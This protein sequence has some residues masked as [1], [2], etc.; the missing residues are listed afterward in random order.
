MKSLRIIASAVILFSVA[1]CRLD[2][3]YV[4]GVSQCSEDLWRDEINKELRM[5]AMLRQ[6]ITLIIKSVKDDSGQQIEDIKELVAEGVDLLVVSPNES[7]ALTPVISE[8]YRSGIPVI[9]FDRKI[10]TDDYTAFIGANNYRL[11]RQLARYMAEHIGY[12]GNVVIIR[13]LRGSTADT[14]RYE[15]FMDGISHYPGIKVVAER[16]ANYFRNMANTEMGRIIDSLGISNIDAVFAMNDQMAAGVDDAISPYNL[17]KKPFIVGIDGLSVPGG[18]LD[19]IGQGKID[20]S[21]I[22]PTGGDKIMDVAWNILNGLPYEK[23]NQLNSGVIDESNYTTYKLQSE[24]IAQRQRS[25]DRLSNILN[26]SLI[27]FNQQRTITYILVLFVIVFFILLAALWKANKSK[28]A[29]NEKLQVQNEEIQNKV[30]ILNQ[31]KDKLNEISEQLKQA[32]NAK[33]VFFTDIS[34]EFKTPLTLITGTVSELLKSTNLSPE[35]REMLA[36]TQRNGA[37]L[38]SLLNQILEFRTYENGKMRLRCRKDSLDKFLSS[39]NQLFRSWIQQKQIKFNFTAQ[40]GEDESGNYFI[41]FDHEKVEKIYFNIL[42]N[43]FKFTE[44][45]GLINVDLRYETEDGRKVVRLAIFNS[46]SYIPKEKQNDIFRRFYRIDD[47]NNSSGIGLALAKALTITHKGRI[48]VESEEFL[49]T[50]F[51]VTLPTDLEESATAPDA[52]ETDR[53]NFTSTEIALLLPPPHPKEH[54]LEQSDN[55]RQKIL[56][57]E[58]NDDMRQY[59]FNIL[60]QDYNVQLAADGREGMDKAI[61]SVPDAIISDVMMPGADG[62]EVAAKLKSNIITQDIPIILLTAYGSDEQRLTGYRA[63]ADSYIVKPFNA[64]L[65]KTRVGSLIEKHHKSAEKVKDPFFSSDR[66][67]GDQQ[68]EFMGKIR[69]FF[70]DN[71]QEPVT[72]DDLC[73]HLGVSKPKLYRQLKEITDYSPIDIMN[74][75]KLRKAVSLMLNERKTIS[76]AAYETGFNSPSYF[77]KLFIRYYGEKPSEYVKHYTKEN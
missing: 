2:K 8:I 70:E 32:T 68:I 75:I 23:E 33:L 31:Q 12:S 61:K 43:A 52:A 51:T 62:Y 16:P 17:V 15:G 60:S 5:E 59:L 1:A 55:G 49:G 9:L 4:I 41:S 66:T 48:D 39:I 72:I 28:V 10:Q 73:N 30:T 44:D 21:F 27:R 40:R 53:F 65:L 24:Q 29:M 77:T 58:D 18:G 45:G 13:G 38:M 42:S 46:G 14:E 56:I 3:E 57:I 69:K 50:T 7:S 47:K 26:N 20:A 64:D 22:Y 71:T 67:Y 54:I 74:L 6:D 34:H 35:E 37:K 11:A 76:E 19:Y 25:L 36:I 63:G